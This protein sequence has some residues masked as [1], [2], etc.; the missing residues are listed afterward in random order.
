MLSYVYNIDQFDNNT[1]YIIKKHFTYKAD[2]V[3]NFF[4]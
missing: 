1:K 2:I 3:E 4:R